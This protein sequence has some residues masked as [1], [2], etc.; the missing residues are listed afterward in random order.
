MS[1]ERFETII[2]RI[3]ETQFGGNQWRAYAT[4]LGA[5][6]G[7]PPSED[8]EEDVMMYLAGVVLSLGPCS[9]WTRGSGSRRITHGTDANNR[10]E[11]LFDVSPRQGCSAIIGGVVSDAYN[12]A[13]AAL[14]TDMNHN[15]GQEF[16]Y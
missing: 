4:T 9:E 6:I 3:R 12:F 1:P 11:L 8:D 16:R 10:P 14:I 2:P 13:V 7:E 15:G 5:R